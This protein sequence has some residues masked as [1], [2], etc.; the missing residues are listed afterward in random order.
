MNT[1]TAGLFRK[2]L[3]FVMMMT[4]DVISP[5]RAFSW[6]PV[7]RYS[8][9]DAYLLL[10]RRA[11]ANRARF[12]VYQDAGSG[13]NRGFPSGFFG[14][15]STV[16]LD[17]ACID[18]PSSPI[19]CSTNANRLD[20]GRGTVLRIT[21][22]SQPIGSFAGVNIEEPENWGVKQSGNGY[23]LRGVTKLMVDVRSPTPGGIRVQF[24]IAGSTSTFIHIPQSV[25]YTTL[26]FS[27]ASALSLANVH[28]LFA[29]VTNDV[30]A[31]GGG[32]LLLDN[33]R[34]EPL[35]LSH[36]KAQ[37]TLSFPLSTETFGIKPRADIA[38]GR[39]PFP[40]DQV[41]RNVTTIYESSLTL[42]ALLIRGTTQ[43][44]S[45][46]RAIADAFV[47]AVLHENRGDPLPRAA[48]GASGLHNAYESGDI[49]LLNTQSPTG[50]QTGEVRLA[51]F[52]V[53]SNL[54]GP[55][56]FC[57]ILDGA[58]GGNNAFAILALASAYQQ[59]RDIR[60]LNAARTIG[61]WIIGKLRDNTGTGYGGYYLGYPDEGVVPKTLL[62]GKSTEN[63]ADIFA[64]FTVLVTLEKKLG[65]TVQANVWT[66]AAN[67]A[68]DFAMRMFNAT[69]GCFAAGTVPVGT[70]PGPGILPSGPRKGSDITNI[71]DFLDSNSFT[72]L[73]MAA[74]PRYRNQID[75]R[76]PVGCVSSFGQSVSAAG[77]RFLGYNI[78][79]TPTA[80]PNGIA[81]EFTGQAIRVMRFVDDLYNEDHWEGTAGYL[82]SYIGIAQ[83]LAPFGDGRGF[84]ASTLQGGDTIPPTAQCLSTPFQCIPERVGLAATAWVIFAVHKINPFALVRPRASV[85]VFRSATGY[86]YLDANKNFTFDGCS[87]DDCLGPF[88][89][90]GDTPTV[91]DWDGSGVKKIGV[92]RGNRVYLDY[93]GDGQW[94]GPLLDRVFVFGAATDKP[95]AGDWVGDGIDRIGFYRPSTRQF[96]FDKN[97]NG[98][99]NPGIDSCTLPFGSPGDLPTIGDWVGDGIDRIGIYRPSTRQFCFDKNGNGMWNPGI[100]SCTS[101]VAGSGALPVVGDWTG[102]GIAKTGIFDPSTQIWY[103]DPG[104]DPLLG[105]R[106]LFGLSTDIPISGAW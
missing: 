23:D 47:Y 88:G 102:D 46:A 36:R 95:I 18:D 66:Q 72:T 21:F 12:Y 81:W 25:T 49:G 14:N 55:S 13:L 41:N 58:T 1:K 27:I 10:N 82:A 30:N 73:A 83:K 59:F 71:F 85:G 103:L 32:T 62:K 52:S 105:V 106:A 61:R 74:T 43:D 57:L 94:N 70:P 40:P 91:G 54:C 42:Q 19:G 99:W 39:V 80:G 79:R 11:E 48:D 31:P 65:N 3:S 28:I 69:M 67:V 76:R 63:N 26:S 5:S 68:G 6:T 98:M 87:L 9:T 38:P 50:G 104:D 97:G 96:C 33:I 29:V 4:L 56:K 86:W 93:N 92:R 22:G 17:T 20:R 53:A 51:G 101:S 60:Y 64:A 7:P 16:Q 90:A 45:N 8:S 2:A 34:F 35:P 100:D 84:V 24:G 89:Q 37:R 75:W 44:L 15:R 77:Q 78:V